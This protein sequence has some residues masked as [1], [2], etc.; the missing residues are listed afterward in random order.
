M[1]EEYGEEKMDELHALMR[2]RWPFSTAWKAV[3]G[4]TEA[5]LLN[6]W[7]QK[8]KSEEIR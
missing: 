5:K 2:R 3:Y 6:E 8:V 4:Q 1:L 7:K